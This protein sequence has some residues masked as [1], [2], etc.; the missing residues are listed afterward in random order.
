MRGLVSTGGMEYGI[1][2]VPDLE[3]TLMKDDV[4]LFNSTSNRTRYISHAID[5][6]EIM[7]NNT[8]NYHGKYYLKINNTQAHCILE[9]FQIDVTS[10]LDP[11]NPDF[12]GDAGRHISDPNLSERAH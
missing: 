10:F 7:E 3:I 12:D 4:V 8:I 6:R 11:T 5:I 9:K 1:Q 2:Q